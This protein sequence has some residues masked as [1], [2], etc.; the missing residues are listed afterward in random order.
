M[1]A[2]VHL[3]QCLAELFLG[4]EMFQIYFVE[5]IRT[6]ILYRVIVFSSDYRAVYEIMWKKYSTTGQA[7]DDNMVHA[8]CM[9]HN[10]GYKR[11][12]RLCYNYGFSTTTVVARKRLNVA[13]YVLG[14][15]FYYQ[16]VNCGTFECGL[17]FCFSCSMGLLVFLM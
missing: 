11:T 17:L 7:I 9:L 5:K 8:H 10:K 13:L 16:V 1:K 12:L 15:C 3:W 14:L 2:Y 4:G 6:Y